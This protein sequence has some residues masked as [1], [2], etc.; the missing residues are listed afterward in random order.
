MIPKLSELYNSNNI[1]EFTTLIEKSISF[2]ITMAL[3]LIFFIFGCARIIILLFAGQDF[4]NSVNVLKILSL[5]SILIGFSN[6]F[7]L[8]ILTPMAKD[9]LLMLSVLIGTIVS[10][11]LNLL[12]I[13]SLSEIG[14]AISNVIA[15]LFVTLITFYFARKFSDFNVDV[16]LFIKTFIF[17]LPISFL[18][19]LLEFLNFENNIIILILT[20]LISFFYF[21][22]INIFLIKNEI[23][24]QIL[25]KINHLW[26]NMIT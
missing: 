13:P 15:E 16:I 11:F 22:I 10:V 14:A 25:N 5:L 1:K 7:G 21:L 17:M 4:N 18:P 6:V 26:K 23:I 19:S 3:P 24:I 9:K 2:V 12:L 20:T 8:Q